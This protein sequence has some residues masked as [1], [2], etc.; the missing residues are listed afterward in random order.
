MRT[1]RNEL[2]FLR[3]NSITKYT[4]SQQSPAVTKSTARRLCWSRTRCQKVQKL[5]H[6]NARPIRAKH[7]TTMVNTTRPWQTRQKLMFSSLAFA[8][9]VAFR[10]NCA[11]F[12]CATLYTG[13]ELH[14]TY[15][16][17][18]SNQ[19]AGQ[20]TLIGPWRTTRS[21]I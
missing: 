5:Y 15:I 9:V 20:Y 12:E 3:L 10:R 14:N 2:L 7:D 16:T 11:V 8:T 17:L 6:S 18:R 13:T 4:E 19:R 21:A 1:K